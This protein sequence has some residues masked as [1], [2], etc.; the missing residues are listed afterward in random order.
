MKR[1]GEKK[2]FESITKPWWL[3][4]DEKSTN[5]RM[6]RYI[7]EIFSHLPKPIKKNIFISMENIVIFLSRFFFVISHIYLREYLI[8]G[9]EKSSGKNL[10]ILYIGNKKPSYHIMNL[11]FLKKSDLKEKTKSSIFK[12]FRNIE[13][14]KLDIDAVFIKCDRF[15]SGFFEKKGFIIIP[16]WV[17]MIL[18]IE[19]SLNDF[20]SNLKKSVKEDIKKINK[21]GYTFEIS[22]DI[23]KLKFFYYEMYLPYVSWRYPKTDIITNF[24]IMKVLFEKGGKILFV[25]HKDEYIF[26]GL[27][28]I[29]NNKVIA[30]YAGIKEG[31]YDYVK[32]GIIAASYYF[33]IKYSK[34]IGA[35]II[36]LG[37][38]RSFVQDGLFFYKWK[39]GAKIE[40]SG[41]ECSEVYC[42]KKF[43]ESE[44]IN[45][46]L[47]NNPFIYLKENKLVFDS[48]KK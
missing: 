41:N 36:D 33:L 6:L 48:F 10:K 18:N 37:S 14:L 47:K 2:I 11:M 24:Y 40:K 30:T 12:V 27:F 35:D 22:E 43:S 25:K 20:K 13:E 1:E 15:Y 38:C 17:R 21:I 26:G 3:I 4:K 29:R 31:K 46:F 19:G 39:W 32:K 45:S 44:S 34:D 23:N 8:T 16:E 28:S 9:K 5:Y 42:I 7:I